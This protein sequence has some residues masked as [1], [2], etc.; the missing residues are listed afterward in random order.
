MNCIDTTANGIDFT[1]NSLTT[2]DIHILMQLLSYDICVNLKAI[3]VKS[4]DIL[5]QISHY[6]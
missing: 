1:V 6:S 3:P 4:H 2:N 5:E